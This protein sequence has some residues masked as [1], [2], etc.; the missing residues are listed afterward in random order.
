[1]RTALHL[2]AEHLD[3]ALVASDLVTGQLTLRLLDVPAPQALQ[4]LLDAAGLVA[5]R[6][7]RT[8]Q[9]ESRRE[10]AAREPL[11]TEVHRLHYAKAEEV[12]RGLLGG[13]I[14]PAT[15]G[16][17]S[18]GTGT[19]AGT[20]V[21]ATAASSGVGARAGVWPQERV[22]GRWAG[23]GRVPDR[24]AAV[25]SEAAAREPGTAART[26]AA[27][28]SGSRVLSARGSVIPVVRT[29]QLFITDVPSR[30]ELARSL[31][32]QIDI[33]LRQV[34]IEA[35]IVQAVDAFGRSLGVKLG[36]G[37]VGLLSGEGATGLGSSLGSV[38]ASN[39]GSTAALTAETG[40][41]SAIPTAV[42][43][44]AGRTSLRLGLPAPAVQGS[45][46]PPQTVALIA[47][48]AARVLRVEL[49]ALEAQGQ[50]RVVSSPR[51]V[52]ADQVEAHVKQG[53]RVPY[54]SSASG[55]S[56]AGVLFQEANLRLSVTPQ[57]TPDGKV[58]LNVLVNKDSLGGITPD[59]REINTREVR[60]QVLVE[61]G[62]TVVLGGIHEQEETDTRGGVPLLSELPFVG[63]L[64][65]NSGRD[66]R[67]T[68]L[69]IFI[70]P[71]ILKEAAV[72]AP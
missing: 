45:E 49:A 40:T 51:I 8:L 6:Q 36:L 33:P 64:F 59:G 53:F 1:M 14:G 10:W 30:L 27:A 62:G 11:R 15:S 47:A 12:A 19:A 52:T 21:D 57:L 18:L 24:P 16:L 66:T 68:E 72:A 35:R 26:P 38:T 4:A 2:V 70:T 43:A 20:P 41:P 61:D 48:S 13:V 22:G 46:V 65:R 54:R 9:V 5:R 50:G 71:T 63:A 44:T 29:N 56:G 55:F 3:L 7:G 17:G 42:A 58:M 60:T 37:P 25:T 23:S 32:S 31:I 28:V 39:T 34:L 67:R 69:L